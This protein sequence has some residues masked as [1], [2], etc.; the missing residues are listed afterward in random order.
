MDGRGGLRRRWVARTNTVYNYWEPVHLLAG[1]NSKEKAFQ[2]WEYAPQYAIR[3]WA[4]IALHAWVPALMTLAQLPPYAGFFVLRFVLAAVSSLCDAFL[5]DAVARHINVR[6]ARYTLVFLA[7]CAGM[8][9]AS[10]GSFCGQTNRSPTSLVVCHVHN[11]CGY[12]FRDGAFRHPRPVSHLACYAGF[13]GRRS[14]RLALW[15]GD[16]APLRVGRAIYARQRYKVRTLAPRST[17]ARRGFGRGV[18][19]CTDLAH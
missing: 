8:I 16:S 4:Y 18:G 1:P 6:T 19:G 12:G 3:S 7:G 5:Y 11:Q 9:S 2:T 17:V 13:C 10:S 15:F 14:W